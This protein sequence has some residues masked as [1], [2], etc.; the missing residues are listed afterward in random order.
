MARG[1]NFLIKGKC[2]N[3]HCSSMSN[4]AWC[5]SNKNN[6]SKLHDYCPHPDC[7]CQNL[8]TFSPKQFQLEGNGFTK[9]K[10]KVFKGSQKA[11]NLFPE[12]TINTL[13]PVIGMAVEAKSRKNQVGQATTSIQKSISRCKV[14]SLTDMHGN[15]LHF[16]VI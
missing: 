7:K 14:L 12:P 1:E 5:D 2:K 8:F 13:A 10:K 11:W 6:I 15:G 4:T 16:K 9:T 3:K